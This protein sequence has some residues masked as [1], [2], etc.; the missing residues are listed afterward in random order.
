MTTALDALLRALDAAPAPV[1]VF[2]RDDGGGWADKRLFALLA[3]CIRHGVPID[4]AVIPQAMDTVL[5]RELRSRHDGAPGLIGLHQHGFAHMN[6]ES[7]GCC[8]EF[9]NARPLARQRI[10]L[11]LGRERLRAHLAHR[12]DAIFTPPWNDCCAETP[13][14]LCELGFQAISRGIAR[15]AQ[16]LLP[17]LAVDIDWRRCEQLDRDGRA[18]TRAAM[19]TDAD[20]LPALGRTF[21]QALEAR[22]QA[23]GPVGLLLHH[24]DMGD[25]SLACLDAFFSGV[26]GHPRLRWH[27]MRDLL[28]LPASRP[29]GAKDRLAA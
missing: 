17:E 12:L 2:I 27:A 15:P 26:R 20:P 28:G 7:G 16:A 8:S 23:G 22:V 21:L 14:L 6:H 11:R 25:E 9:G 1:S 29:A 3:L 24:A 19:P 5:A 13:A 10:D 4:V 18:A